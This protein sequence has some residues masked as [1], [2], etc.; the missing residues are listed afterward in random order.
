MLKEATALAPGD[1]V[2]IKREAWPTHACRELGGS[3]WSASVISLSAA[4]ARV[5]FQNHKASDGRPYEDVR[6]ARAF[7]ALRAD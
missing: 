2:V 1:A 5:R 3:G 7:I 4:T 6:V